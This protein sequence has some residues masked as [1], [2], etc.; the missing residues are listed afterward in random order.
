MDVNTEIK[1]IREQITRLKMRLNELDGITE[2]TSMVCGHDIVLEHLKKLAEQYKLSGLC[3]LAGTDTKH[4]WYTTNIEPNK[5]RNL[6][7]DG[8]TL[9]EFLSLFCKKGVWEVLE[10]AFHGEL[11]SEKSDLI[12]FLEQKKMIVDNN[13]TSKGF[14]C[15]V[16]LG[17]L[18]FNM[19]K[20]L[21]PNKAIEIFQIVYDINGI[22]YGEYLPYTTDE[23]MELISKHPKY[24]ELLSKGVSIK[25]ISE[26]LRQNNV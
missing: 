19:T 6:L 18:A 12:N 20:K 1:S 24:P 11:D 7:E 21:D 23:F 4:G 14:T 13:L 26:Y 5:I 9:R 16:V 22:N 15:Y 17:H 10:L 3:Q 2:P 25:D 8:E